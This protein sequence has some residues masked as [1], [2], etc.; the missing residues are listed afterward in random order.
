MGDTTTKTPLRVTR[1]VR[2][3]GKVDL[4]FA[5]DI[6]IANV[7]VKSPMWVVPSDE[8]DDVDN[9]DDMDLRN[10]IFR[11]MYEIQPGQRRTLTKGLYNVILGVDAVAFIA[12]SGRVQTPLTA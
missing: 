6:A 11:A 10:A 3:S 7:G 12:C 5:G 1:L 2:E 8:L 4:N 9:V